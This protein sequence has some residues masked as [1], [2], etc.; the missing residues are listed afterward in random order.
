MPRYE[1]IPHVPYDPDD[2]YVSVEAA[3]WCIHLQSFGIAKAAAIAILEHAAKN[4]RDG[5]GDLNWDSDDAQASL[6]KNGLFNIP[7]VVVRRL[8]NEGS[9]SCLWPLMYHYADGLETNH[10][11]N[12]EYVAHHINWIIATCALHEFGSSNWKE[13]KDRIAEQVNHWPNFINTIFPQSVT[14]DTAVPTNT[15]FTPIT[16]EQLEAIR[17]TAREAM[18]VMAK[19]RERLEKEAQL[20]GIETWLNKVVLPEETRTAIKEVLLQ[21]HHKDKLFQEWGLQDTIDYGR[22]MT[23]LFWGGPGLGKTQTAH[24]I[25]KALSAELKVLNAGHIQSSTPGQANRNISEAFAQAKEKKQVLF[26]DECDS[27]ITTRSDV[28][29][30]L[31]SEINTLLTEIEKFEGVCILATN[32]IETLDEAL[33]RRISLIVEFKMPE[34][35]H[36]ESLWRSLLPPKMPLAEDVSIEA[37]AEIALTGGQ[38]KNVILTAARSAVAK[39]AD[40]LSLADFAQAIKKLQDGQ[41]KIGTAAKF[42]K[43]GYL[44]VSPQVTQDVDVTKD[45]TK[46][47]KEKLL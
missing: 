22:G 44:R 12:V 6:H 11:H 3:Q 7:N 30:I 4:D 32:R 42:N 43:H 19:E 23:M 46:F 29:M 28:G 5:D 21:Q 26:F 36:R 41:G 45:I 40:K 25:A 39:N 38:I 37:L 31:A 17:D 35:H 33:E 13:A 14:P 2:I 10:W 9:G 15:S 47:V 8:F 27:L 16:K 18:A 1:Q 34:I 24:C 20:K